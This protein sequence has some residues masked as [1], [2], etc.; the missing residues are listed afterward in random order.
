MK[1]KT[2]YNID[3]KSVNTMFNFKLGKYGTVRAYAL[4]KLKETSNEEDRRTVVEPKQASVI[5]LPV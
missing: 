4:S 1:N 2:Y 3:M 5:Q